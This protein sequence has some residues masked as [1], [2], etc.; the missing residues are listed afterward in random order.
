MDNNLFKL[1]KSV[2]KSGDRLVIYNPENPNNSWVAIS[3]EE[4]EKLTKGPAFTEK[5]EV[6]E[7]LTEVNLADKINHENSLEEES[8]KNS[9]NVYSDPDIPTSV[10]EVL[11]NNHGWQIPK[12]VKSSASEIIE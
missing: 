7:Q 4:Y 8:S 6:A 11:R 3:L 5:L 12:D 9:E 2:N 10:H 1:L